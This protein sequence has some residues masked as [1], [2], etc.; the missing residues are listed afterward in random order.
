MTPDT[1]VEDCPICT[2]MMIIKGEADR[3]TGQIKHTAEPRTYAISRYV[4]I[5]ICPGCAERES[6]EG[7][8]WER[9]KEQVYERAYDPMLPPLCT[10]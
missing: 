2:G 10:E 4:H 6:D 8:W 5:L 7:W 3:Y 9:I 1:I